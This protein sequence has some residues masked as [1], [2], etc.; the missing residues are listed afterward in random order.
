MM[1][2]ND[3][4]AMAAALKEQ[5]PAA[6]WSPNKHVQWDMDVRALARVCKGK[7]FRFAY[8]KFYDACGGLFFEHDPE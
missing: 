3:F 8:Q 1:T 2:R 7:N 5:R 6:N 4:Q